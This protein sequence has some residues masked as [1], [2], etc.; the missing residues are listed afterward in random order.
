VKPVTERIFP[1]TEAGQAH[2]F[3]RKTGHIGKI[4]LQMA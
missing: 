2:E 4:L 1:L 3:M